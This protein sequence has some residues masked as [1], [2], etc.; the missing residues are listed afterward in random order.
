LHTPILL[1]LAALTKGDAAFCGCDSCTEE[2]WNS[3][4]TDSNGSY[5]CGS[6]ITW[7]QENLF[8][9]EESACATVSGEFID[10][11]CGP[12]CD[13]LKCNPPTDAPTQ[14]PTPPP[15]PK[16]TTSYC[17]CDSCSQEVWETV[18]TD[19]NGSY[20]C[21][22]RIN[23]LKTVLGY[24][25]AQACT[26]VSSEFPDGPC[27]P[28][29]DPRS[30]SSGS[31]KSPTVDP[32]KSPSRKPTAVPTTLP[33]RKPTN[34]PI[35]P[36]P[37]LS[38]Q[39][40]GGAVDSTNDSNQSCTTHLWSPTRD[41]SMHCFAY[42]G[43]GDPCHLNNNNDWFDGIFKDPSSCSGDTFYLWDEPDTQGRDYIWAGQEWLNYSRRFAQELDQ[44]RARGMKVTGPLL[45]AGT[46]GVIEENM[47]EFFSA[48][49]PPCLDETDSAYID[50][51]AINGFCGPWNDASGGCRS[52]ASFLY[53]E[54]KAVSDA[55]GG[56]PVYLTNWSRLQTSTPADQVDAIDS[57]DEFFPDG[58][59]GVVK[60]VYWFGARDYGGGA[61]TTSYLTNVVN[62]RTLGE[63]WRTKCDSL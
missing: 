16:T 63:L 20:A 9:D 23:W 54:A 49:G 17:G 30:C 26:K 44:M 56:I 47:S 40:C 25:E 1:L 5:T 18:A 7:L 60:R 46:S 62:G 48:C 10:G 21:G 15:T 34:A 39:R 3:I 2:I 36:T 27:G 45:K 41:T 32:T 29:C 19:S 61:E 8:I 13:P 12:M 4:A 51:I 42:G 37:P 52:G 38:D 59:S 50:I 43:S 31:S 57:I 53:K 24:D 14:P 35:A 11:P 6:R 28:S 55:S 22:A 58:D 33:S